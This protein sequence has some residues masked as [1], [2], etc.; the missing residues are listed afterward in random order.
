MSRVIKFRAWDR[1]N[2]VMH[3]FDS[4]RM[5]D[6][7]V[8][9]EN[10]NFNMG[11]GHN[12]DTEAV[13][14][15]FTGLKDSKGVDIYEGDIMEF[16]AKEWGNS[17]NNRSAVAFSPVSGWMGVGYPS[18]WHQWVSVIGNIHQ[19]PELLQNSTPVG[20]GKP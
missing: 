8:F 10:S 14:M 11:D 5:M 9:F 17:E 16:D 20:G 15:Q 19:H 1:E 13:L 12:D 2:Q 18:D 4:L 7:G 3:V 6:N